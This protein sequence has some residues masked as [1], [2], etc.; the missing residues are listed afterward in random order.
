MSNEHIPFDL[1]SLPPWYKRPER[2]VLYCCLLP[3]AF[4][5]PTAIGFDMSMT[6]ALQTI[7]QFYEHFGTPTS[8]QLGFFGAAQSLGGAIAMFI[9]PWICDQF[10][11]RMPM[12]IGSFIII[13]STMG[14]A[15]ALSFTMFSAF[16]MLLGIGIGLSQIGA[17]VLVAELAHPKERSMFTNFYNTTIYLGMVVG[18]WIAYDHGGGN[19]DSAL[20][21]WELT[22]IRQAIS[23]EKAENIKILDFVKNR[24]LMWRAFL[25]MCCGVFSQTSGN[26]LVS[27]YLVQILNAAGIVKTKE[28][29]LINGGISTWAWIVGI[30]SAVITARFRRRPVLLFGTSAMLVTF[31]GWTIAQAR[32]DITG[33]RAAGNAVIAMIFLFNAAGSFA[34]LYMVVSYPIEIS[35]YIYRARLWAFTTFCIAMSGFFNQ[36][37]NP[38]GLENSGW[39][40]YIYYDV[41]IGCELVIIYFLF[42]ETGGR[43]LEEIAVVF[44]GERSDV[45]RTTAEKFDMQL[46]EI[47]TVGPVPLGKKS[48]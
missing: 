3:A 28:L 8:P 48:T 1:A 6:N 27:A 39:K 44:D 47:E 15:W 37:V 38:I 17:P 30:V 46:G 10:G 11:R 29:T 45:A 36:Y 2:I 16:K 42:P 23:L 14:Q 22:K 18:A 34:W 31:I 19:N 33:S 4:I 21:D 13:A 26:G 7:P 41:W 35:P 40:Y 5:T 43:T 25:C 20:V 12:M 32:Y 9:A 24:G